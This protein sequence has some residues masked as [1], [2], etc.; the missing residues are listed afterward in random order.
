MKSYNETEA[1]LDDM[2]F[3][4]KPGGGKKTKL[5]K[6]EKRQLKFELRAGLNISEVPDLKAYLNMKMKVGK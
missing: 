4:S 2:F 5:N 3:K 1:D 6:G